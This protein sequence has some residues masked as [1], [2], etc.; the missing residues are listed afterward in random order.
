VEHRRCNRFH[1]VSYLLIGSERR[2]NVSYLVSKTELSWSK[3]D[4]VISLE[5]LSSRAVHILGGVLWV[6]RRMS[7]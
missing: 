1:K 6:A 7:H 5:N 3:K 2:S 4:K